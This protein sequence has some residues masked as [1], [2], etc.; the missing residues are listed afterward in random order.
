MV[1]FS[2]IVALF[3]KNRHWLGFCLLASGVGFCV[4]HYI[5][6]GG[7]WHVTL[8]DHGTLGLIL[9]VLGAGLSWLKPGE[10]RR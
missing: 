5:A 3:N 7:I 9:I 6:Y 1:I 2:K 8:I 4:E 10:K